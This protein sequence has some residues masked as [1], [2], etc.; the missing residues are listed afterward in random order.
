[1][2][3]IY[4]ERDEPPAPS[5]RLP[6]PNGDLLEPSDFRGGSSL[7]VLFTHGLRCSACSAW[8]DEVVIASSEL[9]KQ[10]AEVLVVVPQLP[11][12]PLRDLGQLHLLVD[13]QGALRK[14]YASIFEFDVAGQVMSFILNQ[15]GAPFRAWIGEEPEIGV[16]PQML[17]YLEAAALLCPE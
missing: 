11:E 5:L 8:I 12:R 3:W 2:P 9:R 7:V 14:A 13:D 15:F 16:L 17:K 10:G 6:T 4:F 1:M